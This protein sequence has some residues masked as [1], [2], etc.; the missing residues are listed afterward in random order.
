M[1]NETRYEFL[2]YLVIFREENF[3]SSKKRSASDEALE[4]TSGGLI[5]KGYIPGDK[6]GEYIPAFK[7]VSDN[8]F[9]EGASSNDRQTYVMALDEGVAVEEAKK[10]G[11]GTTIVDTNSSFM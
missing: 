2:P 6:E 11:Y 3:M 4:N 7:V 9:K 10:R 8:Y 1:Y 5:L